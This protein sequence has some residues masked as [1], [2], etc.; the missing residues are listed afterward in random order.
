MFF[1]SI[2]F[3]IQFC[4]CDTMHCTEKSGDRNLT[5]T[6]GVR[7]SIV[8]LSVEDSEVMMMVD[9]GGGSWEE[10]EV[11][12]EED[13]EVDVEE[14]ASGRRNRQTSSKLN[15]P[16]CLPRPTRSFTSDHQSSA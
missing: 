7:A 15:P 2:N 5:E 3:H 11:E 6:I 14:E 13:E 12:E 8:V 9:G 10:E 16:W 4:C 1:Q